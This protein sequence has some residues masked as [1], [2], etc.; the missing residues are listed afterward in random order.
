MQGFKKLLESVRSIN[1][2]LISEE[3]ANQMLGE[4]ESGINQ[5]KTDALAEGQALGFKE[6]YDEGKRIASDEAKKSMD[7]LTEQLDQEATEK[8]KSVL[9][10][11]TEQHAEK[12]QAVY[13]MLKEQYVP[14]AEYDKLDSESADKL[15]EVYECTCKKAEAEK[16]EAVKETE[17]KMNLKMEE[18]EKFLSKKHKASKLLMESKLEKVNKELEAEKERKLEILSEQVEKYLNYALEEKIPTKQLISEQKYQ[19][20]QKALE[21]ITGIL[22]INSIIQ[23]SKDGVFSDYENIIKSQKE[24]TNKLLVENASLK[25]QINKQEAKLLLEEKV[26]KCVPAEAT[27]L[28]NYF[29]NADS[30]QVIEEQIDDARAVYKRL[31]DEKRKTLV[32]ENAKKAVTKPSTVVVENKESVKKEEP[33]KQQVVITESAKSEDS[34]KVPYTKS[35]F[36]SVYADMLKP[37]K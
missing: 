9:D 15:K 13:D 5:I 21:K 36:A 16:A 37:N 19:A 18:R 27:F 7:A 23:E 2:D 25:S 10:M 6:G 33:V 4:Y 32:A 24:E 35:T 22:K 20:S 12:L 11:L 30:K 26:K 29:K 3:A 14:K 17:E 1:P 31:Y 8:L 28:R 34:T